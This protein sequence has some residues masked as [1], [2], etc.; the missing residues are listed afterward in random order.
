MQTDIIEHKRTHV[1]LSP[2]FDKA[3]VPEIN[4]DVIPYIWKDGQIVPVVNH[5]IEKI[6]D[7]EIELY[8]DNDSEVLEE[9][10]PVVNETETQQ[11]EITR[12]I[13]L[14]MQAGLP[15]FGFP[16]CIYYSH[17]PGLTRPSIC[18]LHF[19]STMNNIQHHVHKLA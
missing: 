13:S 2:D 7:S 18:H 1:D 19:P 11:E 4:D 3:F 10:E 9:I 15:F 12:A 14:H 6:I 16:F 17:T 5:A 8:V